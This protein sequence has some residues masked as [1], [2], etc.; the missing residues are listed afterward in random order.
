MKQTPRKGA[1]ASDARKDWVGLPGS[2]PRKKLTATVHTLSA[3]WSHFVCNGFGCNATTMKCTLLM[4]SHRLP[5]T[6]CDVAALDNR[7]TFILGDWSFEPDEPIDVVHGGQTGS[8]A[9]KLSCQPVAR[10]PP[11]IKA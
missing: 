1:N 10:R 6:F 7:K 9:P 4:L 2:T 8:S 11:P 3:L 5:R